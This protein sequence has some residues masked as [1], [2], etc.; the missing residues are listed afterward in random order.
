MINTKLQKMQCRNN[1]ATTRF[2][3]GFYVLVINYQYFACPV[4]GFLLLKLGLLL[5]A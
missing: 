4:H 5:V 3:F 1:V 2:S